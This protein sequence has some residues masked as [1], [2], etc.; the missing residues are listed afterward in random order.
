MKR[1]RAGGYDGYG[2]EPYDES[3]RDHGY[4]PGYRSPDEDATIDVRSLGHDD[5][6]EA[7]AGPIAASRCANSAVP[8]A[9]MAS[10]RV[11]AWPAWRSIA[12]A[13][14]VASGG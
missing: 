9:S 13:C 2:E 1:G 4:D 11:T 6:R 7:T 3:Y 14:R 5:D 10:N 8:C 12:A